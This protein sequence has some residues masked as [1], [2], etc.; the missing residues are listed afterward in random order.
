VSGRSKNPSCKFQIKILSSLGFSK[1]PK[2]AIATEKIVL[3]ICGIHQKLSYDVLFNF[4]RVRNLA[5]QRSL[6][7]S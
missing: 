1:N 7:C 5:G 6:I 3:E 2:M 4:A